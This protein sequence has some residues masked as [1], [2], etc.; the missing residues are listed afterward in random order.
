[1]KQKSLV[2]IIVSLLAVANMANAAYVVTDLDG[3]WDGVVGGAFVNIDNVSMPRTVKWGQPWSQ[4]PGLQSGMG[5]VHTTTPFFVDDG[6]P[7]AVGTLSHFNFPV[8]P[9]TA[10]TSADLNVDFGFGGELAGFNPAFSFTLTIDETF[11]STGDPVLDGDFIGF[12]PVPPSAS[13]VVDDTRYTFTMLGFGPDAASILDEFESPEGGTN[14]TL[15]WAELT[16]A[17]VPA[18]GALLLGGL[19]TGLV[20]LLRRRRAV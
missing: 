11:N 17:P 16:A 4:G 13:F 18:P 14:S 2:V 19:G 20:G 1:M 15:L 12:G 6:V 3:T 10:A 5:F 8:E 9:G 7:F